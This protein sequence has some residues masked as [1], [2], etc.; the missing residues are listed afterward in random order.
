MFEIGKEENEYS[1]LS[2]IDI[3]TYE[4]IK[5]LKNTTKIKIPDNFLKDIY[6]FKSIPYDSNDYIKYI[7]E[8]YK[9][10]IFSKEVLININKQ[11]NSPDIQLQS[12]LLINIE[13]FFE[14]NNNLP[15]NI[16]VILYNYLINSI[17]IFYEE[18]KYSYHVSNIQ[19]KFQIN[20]NVYRIGTEYIMDNKEE[21]VMENNEIDDNDSDK[22]DLVDYDDE[23]EKI[24]D[25]EEITNEII[26]EEYDNQQ[27]EDYVL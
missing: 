9:D 12:Y 16:K 1:N 3:F 22:S 19:F 26:R 8:I 2:K 13:D 15:D 10:N 4:V 20:S 5:K 27:Q 6:K 18:H 17:N 21:I 24:D 11:I 14:I 25:E 7:S 23:F